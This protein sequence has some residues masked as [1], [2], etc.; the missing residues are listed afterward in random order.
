M[1]DENVHEVSGAIAGIGQQ[2]EDGEKEKRGQRQGGA[3]MGPGQTNP[4]KEHGCQGKV[5]ENAAGLPKADGV[6]EELP[7]RAGM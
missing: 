6:G 4:S 2:R 1:L 3:E 7:K 5:V